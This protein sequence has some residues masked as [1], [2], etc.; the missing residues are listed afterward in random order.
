MK[1]AFYV[2]LLI[3]SYGFAYSEQQLV[4]DYKNSDF[5]KVCI[6][7]TILNSKNEDILSLVGN[8]C[9]KIDNINPL[10]IIIKRLVSTPRYR[11][12]ASYFATILL[13]KKL[14]YQF[15]NDGINISNMRLPRTA[16]ILSVVFENLAKKNYKVLEKSSKK[17][18]IV[19][20][21]R[22]YILWK[23]RD[24]QVKVIIDEYRDGK[25]FKRHWY[26]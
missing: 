19:L 16:N 7:G 4:A 13:Q 1:K 14:I 12:N 25:F 8:A 26:L 22:R 2:L 23:T 11:A 9:L 5:E 20:K 3:Y 18:E 15:M 21:N 10:G 6:D 24:K 17:I